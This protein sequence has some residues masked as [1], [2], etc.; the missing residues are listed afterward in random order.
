M[1]QRTIKYKG[2]DLQLNIDVDS[3][4]EN[5]RGKYRGE[6][7]R[8]RKLISK[9]NDYINKL[10]NQLRDKDAIMYMML[11]GV[12]IYKKV[13]HLYKLK[14]K[15]LFIL[16]YLSSVNMSTVSGMNKYFISISK[17]LSTRQDMYAICEK[18]YAILVDRYGYY[19]ITD[20]GRRVM[21][22]I[23]VALKQ[24]YTYFN[25]NRIAKKNRVI[26]VE[27][28]TKYTTE[29]RERRSEVY[30]KMMVP[31][32]DSYIK[33]IPKDKKRRVEIIENWIAKQEDVDPYYFQLIDKWSDKQSVNLE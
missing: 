3:L 7:A 22:N 17:K 12:Q 18:G 26:H 23:F 31:F 5:V 28:H 9:R 32:W 13:S 15:E 30:R 24:D 11:D 1:K 6:N 10:H 21:N 8:L 20:Q 2:L 27:G 33:M 25:H 16:H 4:V 14:A 19:A 29:E